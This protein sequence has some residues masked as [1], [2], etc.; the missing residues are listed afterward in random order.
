MLTPI[1]GKP[2]IEIGMEGNIWE[3]GRERLGDGGNG[4]RAGEG[5]AQKKCPWAGKKRFQTFLSENFTSTKSKNDLI[6]LSNRI[7]FPKQVIS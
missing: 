6:R 3:Q 1:V 7:I 5:T 2:I 4:V